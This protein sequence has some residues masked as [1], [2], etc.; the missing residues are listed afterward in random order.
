MFTPD[1][2]VAVDRGKAAFYRHDMTYDFGGWFLR[3]EL[4]W[5][6]RVWSEALFA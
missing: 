1:K 4:I 6:R 3:V 5:S 2:M